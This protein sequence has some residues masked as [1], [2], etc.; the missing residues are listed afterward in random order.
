MIKAVVFDL[1]GLFVQAPENR[2]LEQL[3]AA[4]GTGLNIAKSNYLLLILDFERAKYSPYEFWS[5]VFV[6]LSLQE[7][8]NYV[9]A[10]Y[11]KPVEP[12]LELYTFAKKLSEKLPIYCISNSNFLQGKAY[13]KQKLYAPFKE[14]CLS[15]ESGNAKPFPSTYLHFLKKNSLS[16]NEC[17]YVDD[18]AI[19]VLVASL[20][21]FKA[22]RYRGNADLFSKLAKLGL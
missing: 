5:R 16:A 1:N 2:I 6:G 10:E 9:V 20:L 21:G 18:S 8:E 12:N 15:H 14:F 19:N 11:E 3:C 7:Y 22:I 4:T 17:V 13:R